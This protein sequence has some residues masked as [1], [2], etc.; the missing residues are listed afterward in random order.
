M[1]SRKSEGDQA[2][3]CLADPVSPST[4]QGKGLG[5]GYTPRRGLCKTVRSE[6]RYLHGMEGLIASPRLPRLLFLM[7]PV[8]G[9]KGVGGRGGNHCVFEMLFSEDSI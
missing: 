5:S 6:I 4:C 3:T 2:W 9:R 8:F 1:A 7:C